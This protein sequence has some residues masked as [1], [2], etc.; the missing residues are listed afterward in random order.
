MCS[1]RWPSWQHIQPCLTPQYW[2]GRPLGIPKNWSNPSAPVGVAARIRKLVDAGTPAG[3]VAVLYRTNGQSEPLEQALSDA[4]LGYVLRGGERFFA[5][6]E[7]RQAV[8]LLRGAARSDDGSSPLGEAVRD[9][10]ATSGW[11]PAPP[12]AAGAARDRWASLQALDRKSV[13]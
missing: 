13:V 1:R 10:L 9:V 5:R 8:L 11:T 3:E 12:A 6:Q 4:G 7:V 2:Y